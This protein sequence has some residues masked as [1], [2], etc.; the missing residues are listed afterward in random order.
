LTKNLVLLTFLLFT[1]TLH[2]LQAQTF[3]VGDYVEA[4][5]FD[6]WLPCTVFKLETN[7]LVPG[8]AG[9]RGYTVTCTVNS[10]SGPHE[11]LMA[12]ADVRPRTASP[13]DKRVAAETAAALARQPKGDSVGAKYG[14]REPRTCANRTAPA[15]GAPS[16]EQA[17]QYVICELEQGDG[18]HALWL[19]TNVKVQV[20][21]VSHPP[22]RGTIE[23]TAATIDPREPA[24]DLRG[25]FTS[26]RCD[27]LDTLTGASDF[28]R[29]HNCWVIDQP[30]AAG[31]CW[32]DTFGDWHC[33]ML[34]GATEWRTNV[35]PPAGY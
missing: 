13:E 23:M 5:L 10:A 27:A 11:F 20:A 4:H 1:G 6:Q 14:T 25:S 3:K 2:S 17:R 16:A 29:T 15:H 12:V 18:H 31:Y 33:G 32:K 21:P 24:W 28:A 34:G 26:Y 22:N 35:L 7:W 9:L 8:A 19:V 30:K